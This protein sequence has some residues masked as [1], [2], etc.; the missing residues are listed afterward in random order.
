LRDLNSSRISLWN[1]SI[2]NF[3][4]YY[5]KIYFRNYGRV[6]QLGLGKRL[7]KMVERRLGMAEALG[8][9]QKRWQVLATPATKKSL[10]KKMQIRKSQ[11]V[12][13]SFLEKA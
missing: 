6:V 3:T 11:P 1:L 9:K 12:H 4:N 10:S 13:S 2:I 7:R 5:Q 8:S